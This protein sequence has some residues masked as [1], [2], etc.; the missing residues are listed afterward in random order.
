[1]DKHK[2]TA[3]AY[4]NQTKAVFIIRERIIKLES[5]FKNELN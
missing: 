2:S 4:L 1:M 3:F 5:C